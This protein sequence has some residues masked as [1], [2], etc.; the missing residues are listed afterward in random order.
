MRFP[1]KRI[2][3]KQIT[4]WFFLKGFQKK[5]ADFDIFPENFITVEKQ[6]PQSI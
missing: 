4:W 1:E 6:G 5:S 3:F 2:S